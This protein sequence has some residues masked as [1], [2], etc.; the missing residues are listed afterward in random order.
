MGAVGLD[1][2]LLT[3]LERIFVSG[4]DVLRVLKSSDPGYSGFGE[5][6]CSF[7][8][9]G[10]VK[11]WKRHTEMVMNLVVPF[12]MVRF[13]FFQ[14]GLD[15]FRVEDVGSTRYCR[16]TI[17]PG[18]WFGFQGLAEP[19]SLVL[20]IAS[21]PHEPREAER[22]AVSEVEYDWSTR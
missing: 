10:T 9:E 8:T 22:M 2:I 15:G 19:Q 6:Y 5:V 14:E 7:I 11:A 3:P 12:G 4:G 16:L 1:D 21:V 20:N 18:L 13:V 17:P